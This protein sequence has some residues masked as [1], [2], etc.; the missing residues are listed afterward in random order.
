MILQARRLGDVEELDV[1]AK[2]S[3]QG[4]DTGQEQTT[5]PRNFIQRAIL[6]AFSTLSCTLPAPF[7]P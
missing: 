3:E 2:G 6:R 4:S 7:N 1:L 5:E